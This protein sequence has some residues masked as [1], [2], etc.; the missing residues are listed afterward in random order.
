MG[1][2]A[3]IIA[4]G[5]LSIY[6]DPDALDGLLASLGPVPRV[7]LSAPRS[8]GPCFLVDNRTGV[9]IAMNH[10]A[11]AH[12]VRDIAFLAGPA[13]HKEAD[14]RLAAYRDSL[15]ALGVPYREDSVARGDFTAE[16]G[17]L[18]LKLLLDERGLRPRAIF[19]ANDVMA[20]AVVEAAFARGM[21]V[22][23]ELIVVGFDDAVRA[24]TCRVPLTT[25]RQPF[26]DLASEAVKAALAMAG[27]AT[28]VESRFFPTRLVVR[29]SCGCG[30][31]GL[32][33]ISL[34][35]QDGG[36]ENAPADRDA[37]RLKAFERAVSALGESAIQAPE[38]ADLVSA[39]VDAYAAETPSE[40][41][42]TLALEIAL[43]RETQAGGRPSL[44]HRVLSAF[45][46][47]PFP[48][49]EAEAFLRSALLQKARISVEEAAARER[50]LP[51]TS[52]EMGLLGT[53]GILSRLLMDLSFEGLGRLLADELPRAGI[54]SAVVS[55]FEPPPAGGQ[56]PGVPSSLRP[57][58]V[59]GRGW[60]AAPAAAELSYPSDDAFPPGFDPAEDSDYIVL[61]LRH[62]EEDYGVALFEMGDFPSGLGYEAI[63]R[64]IGSVLKGILI[65][66]ERRAALEALNEANRRLYGLA[67]RDELTGL[68]NRRGFMEEAARTLE[69]ARRQEEPCALFF[70]DMDG[71]KRIN[72]TCGHDAGD[73]AL[74][75]LSAV[76]VESFRSTDAIGRVGGDEFVAM[77]VSGPEAADAILERIASNIALRNADAPRP[78]KLS[79]SIG[80]A[81]TRPGEGRDLEGL[82]RDADAEAYKEKERKR[83][84]SG[85]DGASG[86]GRT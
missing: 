46:N 83:A 25:V 2:D 58:C 86:G 36:R 19:C 70:M 43:N 63:A 7:Y 21:A 9:G 85:S 3:L 45:H 67:R 27:G 24:R 51:E 47:H 8:D 54:A 14:E 50:F 48:S 57:L 12:G 66:D 44:W 42:F 11:F 13:G 5:D 71:L 74:R 73:E 65:Q 40:G 20:Q 68:L 39:V 6:N 15:A 35:R 37:W 38:M 41:D 61:S 53:E 16:S 32:R 17:E 22:P 1:L 75:S 33:S 34:E 72:D 28:V 52:R 82:M 29:R 55:V 4:A 18:A 78:F 79:V 49:D 26:A 64:Q 30:S 84:E 31:E 69:R 81:M 80:M 56:A 76:L 23:G 60:G 77:S 59:Y 62:G 10:I